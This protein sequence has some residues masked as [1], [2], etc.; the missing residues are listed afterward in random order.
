MALQGSNVENAAMNICLPSHANEGT[1]VP[2]VTKSAWWNLASGS[3]KK[4]SKPF[5]TVI[6]SSVVEGHI[7]NIRYSSMSLSAFFPFLFLI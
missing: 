7:L 5:P 3:V 6:S 4:F 1:S 2:L